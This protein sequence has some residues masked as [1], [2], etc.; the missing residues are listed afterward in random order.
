MARH[1]RKALLKIKNNGFQSRQKELHYSRDG[2]SLHRQGRVW[3][4][5]KFLDTPKLAD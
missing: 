1:S 3:F 5:S 4:F 2:Y